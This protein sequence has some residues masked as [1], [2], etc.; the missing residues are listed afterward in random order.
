MLFVAEDDEVFG[1][2]AQMHHQHGARVQKRGDEVAIGRRVDAVG[3]HARKSETRGEHRRVHRVVRA[4]DRARAERHRIGFLR[5][6]AETV[7]VAPQRRDVRQKEVRDEHGHRAPEVRVGRH[8]GRAGRFRLPRERA[9][10]R[11]K[12]RLQAGNLPPEVEAQIERHLL[13][14]RSAGVQPLAEIADAFDEL[15]LDERVHVFVGAVDERGLAPASLENVGAAQPKPS[16]L[17]RC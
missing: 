10:N 9:D 6:P 1:Q 14:A 3:D 15:P 2:P 17:R 11:R 8:D 7:V 4:G 12:L 5:R 16:R 13:V